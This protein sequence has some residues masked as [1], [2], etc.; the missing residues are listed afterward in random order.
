MNL[1]RKIIVGIAVSAFIIVLVGIAG[2]AIAHGWKAPKEASERANPVAKNQASLERGKKLYG[3]YCALCHGDQGRGDGKVAANL[4]T[5]P[6]NLAER[7]AHH[8]DGD[9]AWWNR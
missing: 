8:S 6:A 4:N 9:F 5:K 7:A 1:S 3:Q 2:H